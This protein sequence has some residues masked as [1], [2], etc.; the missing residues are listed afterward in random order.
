MLRKQGD[1]VFGHYALHIFARYARA[2]ARGPQKEPVK[3]V[4]EPDRRALETLGIHGNAGASEIHHP[5]ANGGDKSSEE[6]LRTIIAAYTHLKVKKFVRRSG[7][8]RHR[9]GSVPP[10]AGSA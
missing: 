4:H 6:R 2:S 5:D 7:P 1:R 3:P 9:P 8:S 10:A